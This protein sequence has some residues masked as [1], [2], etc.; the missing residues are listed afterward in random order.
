MVVDP[1]PVSRGSIKQFLEEHGYEICSAEDGAQALLTLGRRPF[2]LVISDINLHHLSG[3]KLLEI[4]KSKAISTPVVIMTDDFEPDNEV[5][6][7]SM[8]A[9]EF[10]KKPFNRS[11]FLHRIRIALKIPD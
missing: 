1:D 8:G 6:A 9:I 3:F 11:V 10:I 5:Q 2:D 4:M 7:L